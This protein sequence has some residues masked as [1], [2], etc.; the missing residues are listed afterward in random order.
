MTRE[1][2]ANIVY[3]Q[4][5]YSKPTKMVF[6]SS[7]HQYTI[8]KVEQEMSRTRNNRTRIGFDCFASIGEVIEIGVQRLQYRIISNGG[9]YK[10]RNTY[11]IQR[12]DCEEIDVVDFLNAKKGSKVYFMDRFSSGELL[13]IFLKVHN[14]L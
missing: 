7:I 9:L 1:E 12:T 5:N 14:E 2:Y 6:P 8:G 10:G 13:D 3:E 4:G 11:I